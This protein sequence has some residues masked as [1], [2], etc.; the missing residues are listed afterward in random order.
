MRNF[1]T[2]AVVEGLC[3]KMVQLYVNMRMFFTWL[4]NNVGHFI[5][6]STATLAV[7]VQSL[8]LCKYDNNTLHTRTSTF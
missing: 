4:V 5:R 1:V 2:M 3:E 7:H 8:M 6:K